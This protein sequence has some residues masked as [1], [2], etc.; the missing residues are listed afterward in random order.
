MSVLK[1]LLAATEN[2]AGW[3][4]LPRPPELHTDLCW[5][6]FNGD[7]NAAKAL[8][9]AV[10]GD[11]NISTPGYMATIYMSGKAAVW[12]IISGITEYGEVSEPS[13]HS[14]SPARAWLIAVL[15]ALIAQ[16][17]GAWGG[18]GVEY[19]RTDLCITEAECQRRIDAAV[20]AEREECAIT[21]DLY[22]DAEDAAD[23]IRARG[24]K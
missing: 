8:H 19:T 12:N 6:A 10:L 20:Q 17:E 7:L 15:R 21:A 22:E 9:N 4:N 13:L 18:V 1:D 11:G 23:A 14:V 5:K 16:E 2:G 3:G 24:Q